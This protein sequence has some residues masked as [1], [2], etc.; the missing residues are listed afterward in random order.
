MSVDVYLKY[1]FWS[2]IVKKPYSSSQTES[3][4][5]WHFIALC[6]KTRYHLGKKGRTTYYTTATAQQ[7]RNT[8]YLC[9]SLAFLLFSST[10]LWC[11]YHQR[12]S[13][14]ISF[15]NYAF[16]TM[17]ISSIVKEL[18]THNPTSLHKKTYSLL[19]LT[20]FGVCYRKVAW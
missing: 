4:S 10:T 14:D 16:I 9:Y 11:W 2:S 12:V 3:I 18:T 17:N 1:I 7:Q 8:S 15:E 5:G 19:W 13:F 6:C 20:K